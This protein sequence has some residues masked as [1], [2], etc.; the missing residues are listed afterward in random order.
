MTSWTK[1][2]G[3]PVLHVQVVSKTQIKV[4]QNRYVLDSTV[5]V[6]SLR[7]YDSFCSY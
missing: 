3:H 4:K 5:P 7:E 1:Q 6:E 2:K